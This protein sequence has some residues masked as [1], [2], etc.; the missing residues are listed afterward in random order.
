MVTRASARLSVADAERLLA[1]PSKAVPRLVVAAG[2]ESFLRDRVV[3]AFRAGAATEGAD[4]LRLEGDD[5]GAGE[6][7]EALASI[8]LFG[9]LRR[10]WIRE[11]A[12]LERGAEEALLE[13]A[14]REGEGV[15]VLLTT[16]REVSELKGLEALAA[17]GTL[18][19]CTTAGGDLRRWGERLVEEAGLHLPGGALDALFA[20]TPSLLALSQDIDK[21]SLWRRDDGSVAPQALDA[22]SRSRG[23]AS[24]AR[25]ATAVLAGDQAAARSESA[26]L[27]LEGIGGSTCLWTIAE[28]A[29][30]ALEPQAFAY[31]RGRAA[32]GP[33]VDASTARRALHAVYQADL[34]LKR[35]RVPDSE[36]RDFVERELA[37]ERH[38]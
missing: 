10:I 5:L 8:S 23:E 18:V 1:G 37:R 35:G 33:P 31:Q 29:F 7:V 19:P 30:A 4:L 27:D 26:A 32:P 34:A 21:L 24:A 13:W 11:G 2:D 9:D 12:K 15:R 20:R 28:R 36:L 6:L 38:G 17:R 22:L 16:A 14:G 25:W 3:R